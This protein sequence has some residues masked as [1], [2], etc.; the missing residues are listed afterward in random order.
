MRPA[1]SQGLL[2]RIS[3]VSDVLE[4]GEMPLRDN[5][6]VDGHRLRK[7]VNDAGQLKDP[8]ISAPRAGGEARGHS[9]SRTAG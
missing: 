7:E 1:I 2:A 3:G 5:N 8:D 9:D 4:A 6:P